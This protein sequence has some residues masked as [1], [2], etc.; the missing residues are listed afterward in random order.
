MGI[1]HPGRSRGVLLACSAALAASFAPATRSQGPAVGVDTQLTWPVGQAGGSDGHQHPAVAYDAAD[2]VFLIVFEQTYTQG[3]TTTTTVAGRFVAGTGVPLGTADCSIYSVH[4]SVL[5]RVAWSPDQN[6]FLVCWQY[7]D[8]R[9]NE[10]CGPGVPVDRS[11]MARRIAYDPTGSCG[12][13]R[14]VGA[15]FFV[16][17]TPSSSCDTVYDIEPDVAY[18]SGDYL[19]VWT[20]HDIAANKRKVLGQFVSG[21]ANAGAGGGQLLGGQRTLFTRPPG[22]AD[23]H[24][25]AVA[26]RPDQPCFVAVCRYTVTGLSASDVMGQVI[27][28]WSQGGAVRYASYLAIGQTS[29]AAGR[30]DLAFATGNGQFLVVWPDASLAGGNTNRTIHAQRAVIGPSTFAPIGQNFLV[31]AGPNGSTSGDARACAVDYDGSTEARFVVTFD[32]FCWPRPCFPA[33]GDCFARIIAGSAGG[34]TAGGEPIGDRTLLVDGAAVASG[35]SQPVIAFDSR[36][37]IALVPW[38]DDRAVTGVLPPYKIFAQRVRSSFES[39]RLGASALGR[40]TAGDIARFQLFGPTNAPLVLDWSLSLRSPPL[41]M[42]PP[43]VGMLCLGDPLAV[44]PGGATDADGTWCSGGIPIP[45]ASLTLWFQGALLSGGS[46]F[47]T[48]CIDI[49]LGP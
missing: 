18:G 12:A 41:Q 42:P 8:L 4:A 43:V 30:P 7:D 49:R 37:A 3:G 35:Q 33:G 39:V 5:P 34:G 14:F 15:E 47:L 25:A 29:G 36:R 44:G 27:T 1:A 31:S 9:V 16:S 40:Y 19:V 26:Y 6:E 22:V 2:D 17:G 13:F 21:I 23:F 10:P 46:L 20:D 48:N 38:T 32:L 11:I 28:P 24:D 45:S